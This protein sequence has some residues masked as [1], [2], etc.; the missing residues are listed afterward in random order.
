[1]ACRLISSTEGEWIFLMPV[2]DWLR[3]EVLQKSRS[4]CWNLIN[5]Q[6]A[7]TSSAWEACYP[8]T[9]VLLDKKKG[10][11]CRSLELSKARAPALA[12]ESENHRR[13]ADR[14]SCR[15]SPPGRGPQ[16]E[17]IPQRAGGD[18]QRQRSSIIVGRRQQR[19]CTGL[20]GSMARMRRLLPERT[21]EW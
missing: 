1:M 7:W 3:I 15:R 21:P 6:M 11:S 9:E 20:A 12:L 16:P 8:S 2:I 4:T 5:R 18:N 14:R 10:Q 19:S 17:I 13:R